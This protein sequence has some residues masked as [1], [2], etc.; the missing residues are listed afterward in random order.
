MPKDTRKP[1][2]ARFVETVTTPGKYHDAGGTGLFL[3]VTPSGSK[4]WV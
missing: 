1:L 2:T 3:R 4:Q